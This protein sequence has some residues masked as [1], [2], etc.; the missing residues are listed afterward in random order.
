MF[1]RKTPEAWRVLRIQSELVDGIEHLIKVAHAVVVFGSARLGPESPY[2]H[3]AE[4]LGS[5]LSRAGL[6]VISGGGPGIMEGVNKGAFGKGASSIGLNISLPREQEANPYQDISLYFRYFFVRKFMFMKHA[7]AFAIFP[8]G[9]GTLDELFEALT[10]IQTEKTEP[11]PVVLI[12]T[13]YWQGLITWLK[14]TMLTQGCISAE[15]LELFTVVD[16]VDEA[17]R[18]IITHFRKNYA[19]DKDS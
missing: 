2:Y 1:D 13:S 19:P 14:D 16:S 7:V 9:Y 11:F 18:I 8:G 6:P 10:L 15:D 3:Q 12:G 5:L 4:E 17:A